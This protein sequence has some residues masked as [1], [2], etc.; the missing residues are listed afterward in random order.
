MKA[1]NASFNLFCNVAAKKINGAQ[2][3]RNQALRK[4]LKHQL[5]TVDAD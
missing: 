4:T 2:V 3:G 1:T 5:K